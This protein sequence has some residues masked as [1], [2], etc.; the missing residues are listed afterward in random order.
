MPGETESSEPRQEAE[1]L[2]SAPT[3]VAELVEACRE[4]VRR[5]IGMELDYSPETLPLVD[6]YIDLVRTSLDER[7]ELQPLVVRAVGAYFGEV[8]RRQLPAFWRIPSADTHEWRLCA[9]PVFLSLSPFGVA[10]D[11]V[12]QSAEHDGPS[13]QLRMAPE[14]REV[15]DRRIFSF[16]RARAGLLPLDHP[17]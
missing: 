6:H 3:E 15:V 9:R 7:P 10:Y 14:E 16:L 17:P 13:A 12:Y 2:E 11:A 1:G 5:A 4:Y 8:I